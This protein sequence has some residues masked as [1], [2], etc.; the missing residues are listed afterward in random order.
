MQGEE[1]VI[2]DLSPP[3]VLTSIPTSLKDNEDQGNPI[4]TTE[5]DHNLQT[6]NI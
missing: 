4:T 5:T 2:L 1:T 3:F 6:D